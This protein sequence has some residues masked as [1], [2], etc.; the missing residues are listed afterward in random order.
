MKKPMKKILLAILLWLPVAVVAQTP[1]T[2]SLPY[3]TGFES[4]APY[5]AP[6]CWTALSGET[7][8]YDFIY[9]VH[10][11]SQNLI[12]NSSSGESK[13]ATP[14]IPLPLNQVG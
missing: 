12:L 14:R 8:V 7:Y 13:I 1:C 4:D 9:Y 2:I 3:T 5:L 6:Q 11:G 10:G